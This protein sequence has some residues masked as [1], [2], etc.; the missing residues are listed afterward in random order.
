MNDK[1][2]DSEP[3][4]LEDLAQGVNQEQKGELEYL[5]DDKADRRRAVRA[6]LRDA[7]SSKRA[8]VAAGLGLTQRWESS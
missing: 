4:I 5:S 6:V 1:S 7:K 8:K 3:E 2:E